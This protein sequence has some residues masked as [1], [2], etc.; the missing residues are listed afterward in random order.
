M[1][2]SL[3]ITPL[4]ND[5]LTETYEDIKK[6]LYQ[7]CHSFSA[8]YNIPFDELKSEANYAFAKACN[9]YN[10]AK[11]KTKLI[12]WAGFVTTMRLRT[13]VKK[14]FKH[15]NLLEIKEEI[16]GTE[17]HNSFLLEFLSDLGTEAQTVV[18]LLVE[19]NSDMQIILK[20]N[21][22]QTRKQVIHSLRE[23]LM[24][25]GWSNVEIVSTFHEIRMALSSK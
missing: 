19:S 5:T 12:T 25:L 21:N 4:E 17:D 11:H 22:A 2:S 3:T 14:G 15:R 23:H 24:D 10:P 16:C 8:K 9:K 1:Y 13:Y 20:S 7:I 6:F 18:K